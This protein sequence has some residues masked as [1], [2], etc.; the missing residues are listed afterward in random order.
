MKTLQKIRQYLTFS[1]I[2]KVLSL[3]TAI[4]TAIAAAKEP[5]FLAGLQ[6]TKLYL[7]I[8]SALGLFFTKTTDEHGT[9][10]APIG[11]E[12]AAVTAAIAQSA[13]VAPV[14]IEPKVN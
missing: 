9:A 1:R 6:D 11:P 2:A 4:V 10:T 3:A 5:S 13:V 8:L 7:G 12:Q 14:V